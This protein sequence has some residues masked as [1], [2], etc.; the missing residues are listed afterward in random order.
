MVLTM[1]AVAARKN[2]TPPRLEVG[3][4]AS[5]QKVNGQTKTVFASTIDLGEGLTRRERLLLFNAARRCEVHRLLQN[6]VEFK[7]SLR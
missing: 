7:E 2:I 1:A 3:V 4:E 6:P 5:I